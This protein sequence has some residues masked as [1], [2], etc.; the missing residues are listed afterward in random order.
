MTIDV[1]AL[2]DSLTKTS[3]QQ[4]MVGKRLAVWW[5]I[6][7]ATDPQ[8]LE[9][10]GKL[11]SPSTR[12]QP[13]LR[14]YLE[15]G[16]LILR[17]NG[18]DSGFLPVKLHV[19]KMVN[20]IC[21]IELRRVIKGVE[22]S[23]LPQVLRMSMRQPDP[24][25]NP[26]YVQVLV[27][28]DGDKHHTERPAWTQ[29]LQDL[30]RL[31]PPS[32]VGVWMA[33]LITDNAIIN[34]THLHEMGGLYFVPDESAEKLFTLRDT[35]VNA[36]ARSVV[37]GACNRITISRVEESPELMEDIHDGIRQKLQVQLN[38]ARTYMGTKPGSRGLHSRQTELQQTLAS[39]KTYE[40]MLSKMQMDSI[41]Q[42]IEDV[43]TAL[44]IELARAEGEADKDQHASEADE[45]ESLESML[46]L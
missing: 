29:L 18:Y 40:G 38:Y 41:R 42:D 10:L 8:P 15:C 12:F 44:G 28:E 7:K 34:G 13:K 9:D 5:K 26:N 35:V 16:K 3:V 19:D 37:R 24:H 31:L 17:E 33:S 14:S 4:K 39:L 27:R 6:G 1:Q 21:A 43:Q 36:A 23:H 32:S 45:A 30:R 2:L 25:N 11:W 22:E 46:G 20:E